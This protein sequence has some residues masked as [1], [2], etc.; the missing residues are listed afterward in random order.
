MMKRQ[1]NWFLIISALSLAALLIFGAA[2]SEDH[3][4]A[5]DQQRAPT[6]QTTI[7][8]QVHSTPS[9]SGS[10]IDTLV[11]QPRIMGHEG[12]HGGDNDNVG[13]AIGVGDARQTSAARG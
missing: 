12:A 1:T 10:Q 7:T 3:L 13:R 2:N 4:L 9:I 11:L 8:L 5:Q 6:V